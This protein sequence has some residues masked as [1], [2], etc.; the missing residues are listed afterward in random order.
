MAEQ[1]FCWY[2]LNWNASDE[3]T[4]LAQEGLSYVVTLHNG[5][6]V[7]NTDANGDLSV[8]KWSRD[9]VRYKDK[10]SFSLF[11]VTNNI[12]KYWFVNC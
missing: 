1:D 4:R 11:S 8:N 9:L 5:N 7:I 3:G 10:Y 6:I 12:A 2:G